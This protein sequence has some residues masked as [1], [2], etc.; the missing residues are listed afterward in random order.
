MKKIVECNAGDYS[1]L[2][3]IWE[4]SVRSTHNFLSEEDLLEIR[5]ALIPEYFPAVDLFGLSVDNILRA[6]IGLSLNKIE[7]LF[8]DADYRGLGYGSDLV[9]FAVDRG[10]SLVDVNEQN[11]SALRFYI[12]NGFNIMNRDDVDNAGRPFPIL[13]LTL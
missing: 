8:V 11:P 5:G 7:M 3:G 10:V 2:V 9:Q 13:H 4:R 6:F 1:A 12:A